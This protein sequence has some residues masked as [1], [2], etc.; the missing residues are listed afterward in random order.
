MTTLR[1]HRFR[2][3]GAGSSTPPSDQLVAACW[4]GDIDLV[5]HLVSE[6]ANV[7]AEGKDRSNEPITPLAIA[8]AKGWSDVVLT[9]VLRH[10]ATVGDDAMQYCA[11]HCT[12][13][14]LRVLLDKDGNVNA[15]TVGGASLLATA[16][17]SD[18]DAEAKV[19]MVLA[20]RAVDLRPDVVAA[21]KACASRPVA[22]MIEAEVRR[23]GANC[24]HREL[25]VKQWAIGSGF[26]NTRRSVPDLSV[27]TAVK[28]VSLAS[29]G[30]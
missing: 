22:E 30:A 29:N 25:P 17:K 13:D 28:R 10:G 6:G 14:V 12:K 4:D 23:H 7:N 24:T 20:E 1:F 3:M 2:L 19:A 26:G 16:A 21:A 11:K 8:A 18:V 5:N 15:A 27:F 9:L